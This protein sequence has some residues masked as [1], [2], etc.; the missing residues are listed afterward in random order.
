MLLCECVWCRPLPRLLVSTSPV[1]TCPVTSCPVAL[2]G[3]AAPGQHFS[4]LD[5]L[6]YR[7]R[8][9]PC[10]YCLIYPSVTQACWTLTHTGPRSYHSLARLYRLPPYLYRLPPYLYCLP[11]C[12]YCLPPCLYCLPPCLYCL[13]PCLYCLCT[14][15]LLDSDPYWTRAWPSAIALATTILS[16]PDL[17]RGKRVA[18]LGAGLGV[19][20]IAA[21][22]AGASEVVLLDREPL[23]LQVGAARSTSGY[24]I[25]GSHTQVTT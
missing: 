25:Y 24:L 7:Y 17:V 10:L 16:R 13:P 4:F 15:G 23:A 14:A 1:T 20:G 2:P 22:L 19:A 12:L 8:L 9:S 6:L 3:R 21:A 5:Y 18:D 11:P